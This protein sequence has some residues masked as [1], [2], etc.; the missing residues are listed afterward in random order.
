MLEMR[1]G[2]TTKATKFSC[3]I[4]DVSPPRK[5]RLQRVYS[6]T[7]LQDFQFAEKNIFT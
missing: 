6:E 1:K 3:T 4:E 7:S 2:L 5:R